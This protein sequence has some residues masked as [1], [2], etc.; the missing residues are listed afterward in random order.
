MAETG[1]TAREGSGV[2]I[3]GDRMRKR[4]GMHTLYG[5]AQSPSHN[6]LDRAQLSSAPQNHKLSQSRARDIRAKP[7]ISFVG[8]SAFQ[9]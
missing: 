2:A 8:T 5:E 1:I 4:E 7:I 6:F 9:L 3:I